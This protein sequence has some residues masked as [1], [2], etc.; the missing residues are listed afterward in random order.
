M[1]NRLSLPLLI[2]GYTEQMKKESRLNAF[3][4]QLLLGDISIDFGQ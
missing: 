2:S 3:N 1:N 4:M